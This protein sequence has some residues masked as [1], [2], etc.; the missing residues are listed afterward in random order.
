LHP[1]ARVAEQGRDLLQLRRRLDLA[2]S[3]R[4]R[5]LAAHANAV[6]ARLARATPQTGLLSLAMNRAIASLQLALRNK[7]R[8]REARVAHLAANLAHLDPAAVL[9]RG[10]SL[11]RDSSGHLVRSSATLAAGDAVSIG[12]AQGWAEAEVTQRGD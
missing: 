8:E 3:S 12:F 1:G 10:Y 5:E 7:M 11:V 4:A 9:K 2:L 6:G